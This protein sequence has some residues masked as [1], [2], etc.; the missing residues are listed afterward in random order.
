MESEYRILNSL[1]QL[2]PIESLMVY[3][4]EVGE[5]QIKKEA[6]EYAESV[7]KTMDIEGMKDLWLLQAKHRII[8]GE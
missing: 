7:I 2:N 4:E 6:E 3:S 1:S 5:D 8:F